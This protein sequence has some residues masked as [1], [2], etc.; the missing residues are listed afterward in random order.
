MIA[1]VIRG[2]RRGRDL[3]LVCLM[4]LVPLLVLPSQAAPARAD[5]STGPS[6]SGTASTVSPSTVAVGGTLMYTVSGFPRGATVQILIDDGA[7]AASPEAAGVVATISIDEDGT[8]SGSFELPD[9]VGLGAHW[10]RFRVSAGQDVATSTVRTA[11][12][13]NKSPYFTVAGVTVIGGAESVPPPTPQPD[14]TPPPMAEAAAGPAAGTRPDAPAA[15]QRSA[16]AEAFPAIGRSI[17][18]LSALLVLLSVV[19]VINRRRLAQL[20]RSQGALPQRGLHA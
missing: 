17:L 3:A 4:A 9:Y 15:L 10:L 18:A 12:Y 2:S 1:S 8:A 5:T 11:D 14:P 13:T 16:A 20:R 6:T 19:V 7:L